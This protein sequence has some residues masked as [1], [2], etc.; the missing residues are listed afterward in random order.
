MTAEEVSEPNKPLHPYTLNGLMLVCNTFLTT[1]E[2]AFKLES[3]NTSGFLVLLTVILNI[4]D[5]LVSK[6]IGL[7]DIA[8]ILILFVE[9]IGGRYCILVR[10]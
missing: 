4:L 8:S 2:F 9:L 1:A 6:I 3:T 10:I 7:K 5:V